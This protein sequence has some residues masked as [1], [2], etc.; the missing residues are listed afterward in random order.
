MPQQEDAERC[1]QDVD[2]DARRLPRP[3]GE[4]VEEDRHLDVAAAVAGDDE[5]GEAGPHQKIL[6]EL[7]RPRQRLVDEAENDAEEDGAKH[8]ED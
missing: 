3:P 5:A 2:H 7:V 8:R 1:D 4:A 6:A